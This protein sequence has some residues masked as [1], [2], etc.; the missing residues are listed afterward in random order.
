ML[1]DVS[2]LKRVTHSIFSSVKHLSAFQGYC[3]DD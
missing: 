1:K 2:E 3:S